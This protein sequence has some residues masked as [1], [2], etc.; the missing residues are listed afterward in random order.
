MITCNYIYSKYMTNLMKLKL[1]IYSHT[2]RYKQKFKNDL[3]IEEEVHLATTKCD[4]LD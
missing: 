1:Y 2:Q 3:G 4:I